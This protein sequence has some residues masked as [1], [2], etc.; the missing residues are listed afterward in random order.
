[1]SSDE[2][3]D[4]NKV[5]IDLSDK[6]RS[7]LRE[8]DHTSGAKRLTIVK[9]D[10]FAVAAPVHNTT[11]TTTTTTT[12][13]CHGT[14]QMSLTGKKLETSTSVVG[15]KGY[16]PDIKVKVGKKWTLKKNV[17]YIGRKISMGGWNL[18][19]SIWANKFVLSNKQLEDPEALTKCLRKY[20][21]YVRSKPELMTQLP[22]LQ[23]KTIACWCKTKHQPNKPCHGD[24]LKKL[25]NEGKVRED[26]A[27]KYGISSKI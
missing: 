21:R 14:I 6:R 9:K 25:I 16:C 20:E 7:Y 3:D 23:G 2:E 18:P 26:T 15:L 17:V 22:S 8:D 12:T 10:P 19:E 1:M 24:V 5:V 4:D 11:T 27:I 13:F